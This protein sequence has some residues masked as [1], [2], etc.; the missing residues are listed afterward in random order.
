MTPSSK[1]FVLFLLIFLTFAN[2]TDD[3]SYRLGSGDIVSIKVYGEEELTFE[4]VLLTDVGTISYPFLGEVSAEGKTVT[5]LVQLITLG[6]KDG[7]LI[8]PKVTV[9]IYQYRDFFVNGEVKKP[10]GYPFK[11]GLTLRKAIAI[12]GGLTER[13]SDSDMYIIRDKEAGQKTQKI[14][15]DSAVQPGDIV[16]IEQ[17]FF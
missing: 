5:Q 7:Y 1:L 12:A 2:A 8:N 4:K 3:S 10:G 13:A 16:T 11:P 9:S 14:K 6:L 15:M 17:S